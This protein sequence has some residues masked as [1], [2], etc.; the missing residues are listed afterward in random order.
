MAKQNPN[1][2]YQWCFLENMWRDAS[3][4]GSNFFPQFTSS[5]TIKYCCFIKVSNLQSTA[6]L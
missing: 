4:N 6:L 3:V 5:Y 1:V 2:T